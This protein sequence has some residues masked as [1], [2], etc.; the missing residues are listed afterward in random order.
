[1]IT[2]LPNSYISPSIGRTV[3]REVTEALR[4]PVYTDFNIYVHVHCNFICGLSDVI[5]KTFSQPV[6]HCFYLRFHNN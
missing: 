4:Y 6:S 2:D 5:I 1:M 3:V